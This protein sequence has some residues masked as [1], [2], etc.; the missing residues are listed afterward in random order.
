MWLSFNEDNQ[1]EVDLLAGGEEWLPGPN[2]I[3]SKDRA[4]ECIREFLET[5]KRPESIKWQAL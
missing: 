4:M 5:N 1:I 3:I 2:V